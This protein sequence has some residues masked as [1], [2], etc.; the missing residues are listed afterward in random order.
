MSDAVAATQ[1]A[2]LSI[3]VSVLE[4]AVSGDHIPVSVIL[5]RLVISK[6]ASLG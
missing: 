3:K 4:L 6:S 2:A 5:V 1:V